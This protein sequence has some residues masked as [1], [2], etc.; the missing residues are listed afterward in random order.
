[1]NNEGTVCPRCKQGYIEETIIKH[2]GDM[3]HICYEC[4]TVWYQKDK[5]EFATLNDLSTFK[6]RSGWYSSP[7][8]IVENDIIYLTVDRFTCDDPAVRSKKQS[9]KD[10]CPCC[11]FVYPYIDKIH[12]KNN[13]NIVYSCG[14]CNSV[15]FSEDTICYAKAGSLSAYLA[16][17]SQKYPTL[18]L[19]YEPHDKN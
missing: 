6:E 16:R 14:M 7:N 13:S 10:P 8:R 1:M 15:W 2:N 17:L 3:V 5:I 18:E 12:I 9:Y 19:Y 11:P 4:D